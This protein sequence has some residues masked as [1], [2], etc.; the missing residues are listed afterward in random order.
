MV[1]ILSLLLELEKK[2]II[3]RDRKVKAVDLNEG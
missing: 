3:S 1:A 2:T